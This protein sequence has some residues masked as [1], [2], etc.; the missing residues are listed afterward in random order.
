MCFS[1]NVT[2]ATFILEWVFALW[3]WLKF[4]MSLFGRLSITL[5]F[6]LGLYQLSEFAVCRGGNPLDWSRLGFAVVAFLPAIGM[7]LISI[8]DLHH[9]GNTHVERVTTILVP[10][11]Y[12]LAS[13]WALVFL[14]EPGA[15]RSAIC[16]PRF[17]QYGHGLR[18]WHW[19][20]VYYATMLVWALVALAAIYERAINPLRSVSGWLAVGYLSFIV[21]TYLVIFIIPTMYPGFPSVLCGF[22]IFFAIII[23]KKVLPLYHQLKPLD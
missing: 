12:I 10:L 2:L 22:A 23:V 9:P 13:I 15:I 20:S 17:I 19:F 18:F 1:P 3:A 14:L 4:R 21:P 7:H 11:G 8:L 6:L 5:L 16:L